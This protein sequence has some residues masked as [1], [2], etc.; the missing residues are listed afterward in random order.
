MV[1]TLTFY[2]AISSPPSR[3]CLLL[4]RNLNLEV[5]V[6]LVKLSAGE[7]NKPQ[8]LQLNPLH[9]VPVLFDGDFVLPESRA[10]LAYFVKKFAP[11]SDLYPLEPK[12]RA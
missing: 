7:Q 4:I 1:S 11:E 2:H 10:I 12:A 5:E 9:Q 6:N 8:F 3:A